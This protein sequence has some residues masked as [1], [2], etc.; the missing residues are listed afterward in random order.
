MRELKNKKRWVFSLMGI[1]AGCCLMVFAGCARV[2]GISTL[3]AMGADA[4]Y[5]EERV[6]TETERFESVRHAILEN[7]IARGMTS[8]AFV[9]E[10]G[11]PVIAMEEGGRT[12]YL[13]KPGNVSWF[14]SEKIYIYFDSAMILDEWNCGETA[15]P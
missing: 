2:S 7:R 6:R 11:E 9:R 12:V 3:S 8:A 15:C 5:H 1:S 13:Y 10:Y 14:S 4:D